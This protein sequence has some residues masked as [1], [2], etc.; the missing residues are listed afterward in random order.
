[1]SITV[2][3]YP[4]LAEA[5]AAM[6]DRTQFLGGGTMVVRGLNFGAPEYERVVRTTDAALREIGSEGNQLVIGAGVTMS[7]IM[8]DSSC[9]FLAPVAR[10]VGGPAVRNMGTVGGNLFMR[11]PYGDLGTAFLALDATV[12]MAD[13]QTMPIETFYAQRAG[14]RGLVAAVLV[15]RPT[16]GAFRFRK[17]TRT[18]P[19]GASVMMIAANLPGGGRIGSARVAFG[20][21]GAT[22]LRAK[23]AEQALEGASLDPTGIQRALDVCLNGLDPRDDSIASAWYRREVA[24]VHV[25]RLLLNKES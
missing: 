21:M 4:T 13:G 17:V 14:L 9:D 1:M 25:R 24:P 20:A 16:H 10:S 8:A 6:R 22:P 12:R 7:R 5:A 18:R 2:E 23:D 11:T 19:K 15:P 3:T